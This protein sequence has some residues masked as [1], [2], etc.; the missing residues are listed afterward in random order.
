MRAFKAFN[1]D[2]TCTQGKGKYQYRIGG[3]YSE[4]R[5]QAHQTGFHA[6]EYIL[7]C[8]SYYDFK[9]CRICEVEAAGDID[10]D[11][12]NTKIACTNL[13]VLREL[14]REEVV[15]EAMRYL[16]R[17]P[18]FTD[19]KHVARDKGRAEKGLIIVRGKRPVAAGEEGDILGFMEEAKGGLEAAAIYT[20][21]RGDIRP[22][23]YYDIDGREVKRSA[24]E[25]R[26][27][28]IAGH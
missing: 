25:S 19:H 12:I 17:H 16:L 14:S 22:G 24:E 5:A 18:R 6:A 15:L 11:G 8:L 27:K 21:G 1:K 13:T 4:D 26:P 20:V 2:M 28:K 9:S 7:D 3:T 23:V 10:E